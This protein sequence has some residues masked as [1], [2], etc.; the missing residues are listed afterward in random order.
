MAVGSFAA[1]VRAVEHASISSTL[2][3]ARNCICLG[4]S[5]YFQH[6]AFAHFRWLGSAIGLVRADLYFQ[7][8]LIRSPYS[9]PPLLEYA[10]AHPDAGQ[11]PDYR[12]VSCPA[13]VTRV[14][15]FS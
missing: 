3:T 4:G 1:Q 11:D 13:A 14:I 12:A 10:S 6:Y 7:F 8:S 5:R 9:H 2:G 15:D